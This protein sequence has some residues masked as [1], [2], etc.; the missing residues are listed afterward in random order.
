MKHF[1][2]ICGLTSEGEVD[3]VAALQPDAI[4][5][6]FWPGS[7]RFVHAEDVAVWTRDLPATIRKVGVFSDAEADD[8]LRTMELAN[9]D[10]AQLH[11]TEQ[12]ADFLNFPHPL[13]RAVRLM[14]NRQE[15]PPDRWSVDAFLV[16]SYDARAPGGT[17]VLTDWNAARYFVEHSVKPVIL[18][19]GL[20]P[21]NVRDALASVKP[22]GVDVSSGVETE[23]GRKD[24]EK[25]KRFIE[26]CRAD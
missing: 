7:K 23:P 26:Q 18:A 20:T 14:A 24:I 16:D 1:V 19:G 5:F 6:V 2:K 25:V 21:E 11:G 17:G 10:I 12:P 3:A 13:W 9:L 8:I 22:W 4:G 15:G